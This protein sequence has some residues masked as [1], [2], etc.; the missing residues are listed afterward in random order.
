ML[1]GWHCNAKNSASLE[2]AMTLSQD[3]HPALDVEVFEHVFIVDVAARAIGQGKPLR[4]IPAKINSIRISIQVDVDPTRQSD[5][6]AAQVQL[7]RPLKSA[8]PPYGC[9]PEPD[10]PELVAYLN[11]RS[12][13]AR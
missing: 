13:D 2:Q 5:A 11:R 3:R 6:A 8:E 9:A 12:M 4:E 1:E 7:M 10:G